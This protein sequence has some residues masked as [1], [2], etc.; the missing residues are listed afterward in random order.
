MVLND[1]AP[2]LMPRGAL[3]FFAARL[4]PTVVEANTLN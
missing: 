2:G 1:N 4:A 3:R